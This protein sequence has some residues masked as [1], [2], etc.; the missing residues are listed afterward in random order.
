MDSIMINF[1][2]QQPV[3]FKEHCSDIEFFAE[4]RGEA[5]VNFYNT[6]TYGEGEAAA[7][8]LRDAIISM[9][10]DSLKHWPEG[11]L[12][13]GPGNREILADELETVLGVA[14]I[15]AKVS[16]RNIGLVQGQMDKYMAECRE[17]LDRQ[18]NPQVSSDGLPEEQHGPLIG[19]SLDYCSHSMIAGGGSSNSDRLDWNKDGTVTLTSYYSGGGKNSNF[20]YKVK[21]EIAQKMRDYVTEKNLARLS[22]EDIKTPVMFDCFTSASFSM[23]FD[24]SSLGG[25]P[26]EVCHINCGPAGMAFRTIENELSGILKECRETGECVLNE[27]NETGNGIWGILGQFAPAPTQPGAAPSPVPMQPAPVPSPAPAQS[28]DTWTC[29]HCGYSGNSGKFCPQCGYPK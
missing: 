10:P 1:T 2:T 13:M 23:T 21:P 25:S 22:K 24:D 27:L 5:T 28:G 20:K 3:P 4:V 6:D 18:M 29:S 26:C 15:W 8:A 9:I 19:F 17:A 16:I 12:I 7:D 14:G 11:K